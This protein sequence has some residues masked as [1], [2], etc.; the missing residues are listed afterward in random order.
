M[1]KVLYGTVENGYFRFWSFESNMTSRGDANIVL[2]AC[3]KKQEPIYPDF[4]IKETRQKSASFEP[5][6]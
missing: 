5:L 6:W 2:G 4:L 3:E 1:Q